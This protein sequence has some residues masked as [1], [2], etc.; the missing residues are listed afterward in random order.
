MNTEEPFVVDDVL[1]DNPNAK[2]S[3]YIEK[4]ELIINKLTV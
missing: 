4:V 1:I 3:M 2:T